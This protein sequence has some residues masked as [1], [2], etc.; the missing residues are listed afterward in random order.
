MMWFFIT[1]SVIVSV[2]AFIW[3]NL[4]VEDMKIEKRCID[5]N[6]KRLT[7]LEKLNNVTC[8]ND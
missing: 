5:R 8:K 6:R 7:A 2:V 3:C 4:I 1:F